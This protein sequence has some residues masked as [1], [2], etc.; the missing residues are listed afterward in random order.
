MPVT[1]ANNRFSAGHSLN[2]FPS[3]SR[4]EG[5]PSQKRGGELVMSYLA[6]GVLLSGP[7]LGIPVSTGW[8]P[9]FPAMISSSTVNF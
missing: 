2:P 1:V 8:I 7:K 3:R 9:V 6:S 4:G 5:I